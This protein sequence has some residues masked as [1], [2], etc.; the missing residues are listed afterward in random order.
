M[1]LENAWGRVEVRPQGA[2]VLSYVP[3]GGRDLLWVSPAA[4]WGPGQPLRGGI[5]LCSPWFGPK[6]PD[7]PLHGF[8][9]QLPW[10][11]DEPQTLTD[12]SVR[13]TFRLEDTPETMAW[14]PTPFRFEHEVTLG[15]HLT[16][17][18]R[19]WNRGTETM[20]FEVAW[21]TYF[22]VDLSRV[23]VEGLDGEAYLDKNDQRRPGRQAGDLIVDRP[24]DLLFPR[25]SGDQTID[26]GRRIRVASTA[27]GA[28]VWNAGEKDKTVPDLGEG[29]HLR[30]LC[31]ERGT[32]DSSAV[33]LVP[34]VPYE[35]SMTIQA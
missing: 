4:Q 34:G 25:V 15:R 7:K 23:R 31:V 3:A 29:A 19:A 16:L 12:G 13:A 30:Y 21:H 10:L 2:Q 20:P 28:V 24:L 35:V 27:P 9:R 32:V 22:A 26:D 6:Y 1:I 8:V 14:W 11:S 5:P 18:F 17:V 33:V